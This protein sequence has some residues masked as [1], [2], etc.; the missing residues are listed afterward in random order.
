MEFPYYS[1]SSHISHLKKN[2]Y[3]LGD[4]YYSDSVDVYNA[5]WAGWGICVPFCLVVVLRCK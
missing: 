2:L 1:T 3:S 4:R 5:H